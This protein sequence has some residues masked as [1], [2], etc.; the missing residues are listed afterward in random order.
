MAKQEKYYSEE[1]QEIFGKIP[2]WIIR[3][4]IGLIFIIFFGIV[5]GCYFIKY[6]QTIAAPIVITT[7]N[8][9]ADLFVRTTGRIDRLFFTEGSEVAPGDVVAL[10]YNIADYQSVMNISDSLKAGQGIFFDLFVSKNWIRND[11]MLGELQSSYAEFRSICLD[12]YHYLAQ[13]YYE[14]KQMLLKEQIQKNR[15]YYRKQCSQLKTIE[16][17]IEFEQKNLRRDSILYESNIISLSDFE[18]SIRALLQKE[19]SRKNF[20][21]NL[22]STELSILQMEQQLIEMMIKKDNEIA[23][24]ER[25]LNNGRQQLIT[26]IEQ[27]CYQYLVTSPIKGKISFTN[28]WSINQTIMAGERI[29]SVIPND[30]MQVIGRMVVPSNGFGKIRV[31]QRVNIKLNGYPYME[32]GQLS[33]TVASLS[34]VPDRNGYVAEITLPQGLYSTYHKKINLIQQMDGTGEIITEDLR[35]LERFIQPIRAL[36]DK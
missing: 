23:E 28:Y 25:L 35:L 6:P 12:Y 21:A 24:Y 11:Y 1:V 3:W 8:P 7:V 16:Q 4:G 14:K 5:I 2:S 10:L 31:G 26:Q 33:G 13:D 32:F 15:E 27:W 30:S 9:P 36:F 17:D 22:T 34:E 19:G 18:S 20:E 29:A